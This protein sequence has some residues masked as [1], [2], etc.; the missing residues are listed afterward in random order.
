MSNSQKIVIYL[1][2]LCLLSVFFVSSAVANDKNNNIHIQFVTEH[3]PPF[4]IEAPN[5]VLG[6]ATEI[7]K[8]AMKNTDYSHDITIY[9][10][11]RAMHIAKSKENTCIF[12]IARTPER[13]S[14]FTWINTIAE[15]DASFVA[16]KEKQL[17]IASFDDA[18]RY[19]TAV[20]R[21]DVTHQYLLN[22]GFEEGK[23]L[24]IVNNTH[25][26]LKL[27][28]KRPDIDLILVDANT[29]KYRAR[30]NDLAPEIFEKVFQISEE[31]L[32]YYLACNN[33]TSQGVV[34]NIRHSID[35]LKHTGKL[36]Q[37]TEQWEYPKIKV[38]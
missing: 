15:R 11:T 14:M 13:E 25:S 9:P 31:P 3:L 33:K 26:L 35:Q 6:F 7:I 23:N 18:K 1:S 2:A 34:N 20:I 5:K 38:N 16:L 30:F 8:A 22:E 17:K 27:L 28:T 12:S 4:Q 24:F 29:I 32:D 37:I 36:Q 10:W 21:D 19:N